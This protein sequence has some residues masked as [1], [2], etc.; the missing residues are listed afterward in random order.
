MDI[1]YREG[2]SYD[3]SKYVLV[4]VDQCTSNSFTYGMQGASGADVCEALWK[5]FIDVVGFPKTIYCGF[6]PGLIG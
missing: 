5:F 6:D 1:G 3:G 4:L 2:T